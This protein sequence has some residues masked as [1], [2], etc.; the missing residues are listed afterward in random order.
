MPSGKKTPDLGRIQ[1]NRRSTGQT[2]SLEANCPA[3]RSPLRSDLPKTIT[4][5]SKT[6]RPRHVEVPLPGDARGLSLIFWGVA[7]GNVTGAAIAPQPPSLETVTRPTACVGSETDTVRNGPFEASSLVEPAI[8]GNAQNGASHRIPEF[9][10]ALMTSWLET[11]RI[12]R[13]KKN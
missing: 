8:N 4:K 3:R 9:G 12:I 1:K 13:Q 11:R 2:A 7:D 5:T 10:V 6:W